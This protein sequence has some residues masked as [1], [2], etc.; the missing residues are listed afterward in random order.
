MRDYTCKCCNYTTNVNSNFVR[1]LR[2]KRHLLISDGVS[3]KSNNQLHQNNKSTNFKCKFCHK[4]FTTRS[5]RCRH[6]NKYCPKN[7]FV[8]C[9]K[10]TTLMNKKEEMHKTNDYENKIEKLEK[11]IEALMNKL[12]VQQFN[13]NYVQGNQTN[14]TNNI[15][16]LNYNKTD[17]DFLSENDILRCFM[18]NNHC[19]KK[20]I[21][22]V[23]F[24]KDKP[25]NMN[26]YISCIRG[27]YV[28]I[29]RDNVWQL[30][31]R[32]KQIDDLY[33]T[34][35]LVLE[36]WYDEYKDKYPDIIKSFT[37]YLRNKQDDDELIR[38]VKDEILLMLY[39]KR[40]LI[41][42]S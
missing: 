22:K 40:Y 16:V 15:T 28:M 42:D 1:H 37:R 35:E 19:V 41:R 33:E 30:R 21:E 31:D 32:Q 24:N 36:N 34:N 23:H 8:E 7:D 4:T 20:L 17:Y 25:E 11:K 27:K 14:Q 18:D 9:E 38:S 10:L 13:Y 39:N 6:E 3:K 2:S 26:I 5:S 29:Y 12:Q